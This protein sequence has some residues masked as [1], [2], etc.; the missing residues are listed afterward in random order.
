VNVQENLQNLIDRIPE[1]TA[2]YGMRIVLALVVFLVGKKLASSIS[3]MIARALAYRGIDN[4]V[5]SFFRQLS[6]YAM[7]V[8]VI[9]ATLGQLGVQTASFVA[10]IGAAGLAVGLA[11]QGSLSNFAAGVLLILFRPFRSGNYIEAAGTAGVVKEISIFS[12]TLLTPDNRTITV[13]NSSILTGNIVNYSLQAE[14]RIDLEIGV[15][16]SADVD[17]VK[18][19][20]LA[21]AQADERILKDR[22]MEVGIVSFANSSVN[23]AL[24]VWAKTSEFGVVRFALMENIKKRFDEVG[25]EIPFPQ[26]DVNVRSLPKEHNP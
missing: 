16:Y 5:S 9:V 12:T 15:S 22:P 19:E 21:V 18:R 4:A 6:Y 1:L 10:V 13:P 25:I 20:L 7:L 2:L 14:R 17:A 26:M 23:F 3:H 11:L 8:V 24:R